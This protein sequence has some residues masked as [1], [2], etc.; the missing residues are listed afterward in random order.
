MRHLIKQ[1]VPAPWAKGA[2]R[3]I[4]K[5]GTTIANDMAIQRNQQANRKTANNIPKTNAGN[6]DPLR[7]LPKMQTQPWENQRPHV[8]HTKNDMRFK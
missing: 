6:A 8:P 3:L 5:P 4:A 2:I 1:R 7:T